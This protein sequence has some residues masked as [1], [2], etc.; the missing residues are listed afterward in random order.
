[1]FR[2]SFSTKYYYGTRVFLE[3]GSVYPQGPLFF[4]TTVRKEGGVKVKVISGKSLLALFA[5]AFLLFSVLVNPAAASSVS[6]ET[7]TAP[8]VR[9]GEVGELGSVLIRIQPLLYRQHSV[10]VSLPSGFIVEEVTLTRATYAYRDLL[11]D[12][13]IE[14]HDESGT[15]PLEAT[16]GS[17]GFELR[18]PTQAE[19][20]DEAILILSF[21]RVDVPQDFRGD[22][23]VNFEGLQGQF[24]SGTAKS[25]LV[26][27]REVEEPEEVD[28]PEEPEPPEEIEEPEEPVEPAPPEEPEPPEEVL[29]GA[30]RAFL[31]IGSETATIDG[32]RKEMDV[33]PFIRDGHTF[34]PVRFL[35][36]AFGAAADWEPKDAAVEQVFLT[37]EDRQITITIGEAALS[38][39]EDG[40]MRMV[41]AE[42]A[43]FIENGRTFLPFRAVAEAFGAEVSYGP[44]EG[45]VQWVYFEQ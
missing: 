14:L 18:I 21:D 7:V 39:L 9:S 20:N 6:Y 42:A 34:V 30:R 22:I 10:W 38:V 36:E 26:P 44:P 25:A 41:T 45:P 3:P 31:T 27:G 4:I 37:R 8:R 35:A 13:E 2:A 17:Q 1:M 5:S 40:E 23:M 11:R 29:Y 33:A 15:A 28:D 19:T 32:V 12:L 24:T 43:S 16:P